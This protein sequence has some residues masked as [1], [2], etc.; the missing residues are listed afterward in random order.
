MEKTYH[1]ST[2]AT[3]C[4][5]IHSSA[6]LAS[7]FGALRGVMAAACAEAGVRKIPMTEAS[8]IEFDRANEDMPLYIKVEDDVW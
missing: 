2:Y 4:A 6:A 3:V 8:L 1:R 7:I 5:A